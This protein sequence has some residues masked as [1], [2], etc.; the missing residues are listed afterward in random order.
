MALLLLG[1][2]FP[3][4]TRQARAQEAPAATDAPSPVEAA[5]ARINGA[6]SESP[7]PLHHQRA[8]LHFQLGRFDE[9]IQDYD[10]AIR[11]GAPHDDDSCWER[12]LAQYYAGNY[13]AGA[14]QFARYHRVG[15][16]DIENGLWRFLC[17][18]EDEGL[19]KARAT[20]F[21]YPQQVRLPFPAL[22]ALYLGT[23]DADAVLNEAARDTASPE[24]L[25][26]RRFYAHYYLAKFYEI[27]DDTPR[28]RTHLAEALQHPI[29]HFMYACAEIDAQRLKVSDA[30][31]PKAK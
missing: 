28:A 19:E 25:N 3:W 21:A 12:G 5:L 11:S 8:A 31:T 20:I 22:L 6:I 7:S 4:W 14:E 29:A 13:K 1:A 16:L 10:T 26:S 24:E 18:A 15:A 23:G 2:A 30:D 9:A 27:S 17:I